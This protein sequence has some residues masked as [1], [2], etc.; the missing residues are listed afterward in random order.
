MKMAVGTLN[1]QIGLFDI[2]KPSPVFVKDH[3]YEEPIKKISFFKDNVISCDTKV[4]KIWNK[5]NVISLVLIL[6]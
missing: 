5:N 6:G 4:V 2:R 3:F 1:G